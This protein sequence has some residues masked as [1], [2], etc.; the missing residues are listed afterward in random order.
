MDKRFMLLMFVIIISAMFAACGINADMHEDMTDG[1]PFVADAPAREGLPN[2]QPD[3]IGDDMPI[4]RAMVAKMIALTFSDTDEINRTPRHIS[5][6]DTPDTVWHSKYI[7]MA[8]SLGHL[9]GIGTNFYPDSPLTL[10]QAQFVL[11]RLDPS[12]PIRIQLTPENRQLAISYALWVSLYIQLL[13]NLSGYATVEDYFGVVQEDVIILITPQFNSQLPIGHV[14]TDSGH[15][16]TSG[17]SFE[18]YLNQGVSILRSGQEILAVAGMV[19][20]TPT[21][22]NA[23]IVERNTDTITIFSGGAQRTY[24]Y[25]TSSL[26]P[27]NIADVRINGNAAEEVYVF[28]HTVSGVVNQISQDIV[29]IDEIG[30][31]PLHSSFSIYNTINP[32]AAIGNFSQITI[33][34][35]VA[36]F[37]LRDGKAAAAVISRRAAP[38]HIRVVLSTTDFTGHIHQSVGLRSESGLTVYSMDGTLIIPPNQEFRLSVKEN[39]ELIDNAAGRITIIPNTDGMTEITTISRSW[40]DGK[41]PQY[42]GILEISRRADGFVIINQLSLEEYLYAVIPSEM[43]TAFGLEAAM[44]Q[45]VTARSYAVN[46]I[47]ANRFYMYGANVDDSIQSQ[48]YANFPETATAQAAVRGTAGQVLTYN[49]EVITANFFSTSSGYTANTGDVWINGATWEF[50]RPTPQYLSAMPQGLTIDVGDLSIEANAKAFFT[51]T[52]ITSYDDH[53]PWFRWNFQITNAQLTE[54]IGRNL[55]G[56]AAAS[57]H[58]FQMPNSDTFP[59]QFVTNIGYFQSMA[60]QS[61]GRGGNIRELMIIGTQGSVIVRTEYAIRRLLAPSASGGIVLNRHNAPQISNHFMLPS[62]FMV[63]EEI[64]GGLAFYGGGFGHGVGMSQHGAAGMVQRGY[65]H[66]EILAH[67]YPGT[68]LTILTANQ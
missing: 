6:T 48:V 21:I 40:P 57:P 24:L 61:R 7:N 41:N 11:D 66:E 25:D 18:D 63:F 31:I 32:T 42:R 13:E 14:V 9:N 16:T 47:F 65:N 37:V 1:T 3:A 34:Y 68:E 51:D 27:G 8:V 2:R 56:L 5:F 67:F 33:G 38:E 59:P 10:E 12:N 60:V 49:G 64:E 55:P 43:P 35:D 22:R 20:E 15:F 46:E 44:V 39:L 28:E 29:E 52:E 17:M 36:D 19:S 4:S 54:I 62:T 30:R 26:P 50:D 53:S 23:Y 45:A 58:L